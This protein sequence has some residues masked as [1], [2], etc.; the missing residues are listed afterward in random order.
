MLPLCRPQQQASGG[1]CTQSQPGTPHGTADF[2]IPLANRGRFRIGDRGC[3]A[4]FERHLKDFGKMER[5]TAGP[6]SDLL[7][8]A[9]SVSDDE[10]VGWSLTHCWEEFEF[11]DGGG[12][13]VLFVLESE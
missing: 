8:A 5:M 2:F 11:A 10:P 1:D 6:L 7:T 4:R 12:D 13:L 3:I 9:E